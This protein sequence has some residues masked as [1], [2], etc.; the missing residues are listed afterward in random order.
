MTIHLTLSTAL[1]HFAGYRSNS[2]RSSVSSIL[3]INSILLNLAHSSNNFWLGNT[4]QLKCIKTIVLLST[5]LSKGNVLLF[6]TGSPPPNVIDTA[7]VK[8]TVLVLYIESGCGSGYCLSSSCH[9]LL[10][11]GAHRV[12]AKLQVSPVKIE[13][14][15]GFD[16]ERSIQNIHLFPKRRLLLCR[17]C[18]P[19][20][21]YGKDMLL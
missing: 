3:N 6:S 20:S 4:V 10:A 17:L 9:L 7:F 2:N 14:R 15:F 12:Q 21:F 16:S 19:N 1:F 13:M 11:S 8:S 5:S 18:R